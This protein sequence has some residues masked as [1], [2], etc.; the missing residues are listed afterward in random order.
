MKG[1]TDEEILK[2]RQITISIVKELIGEDIQIIESFFSGAPV[3]TKP[4]WFLGRSLELL[5]DA[6]I[7]VFTRGWEYF[8]GCRIEHLACQ[9]YDITPLYI[10]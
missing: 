10:D 7:A 9:E 1:R 6:D 5:A 3:E 8:R 2:E 4:L